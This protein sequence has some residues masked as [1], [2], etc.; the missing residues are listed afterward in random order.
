MRCPRLRPSV[1]A[2]KAETLGGQTS[3]TGGTSPPFPLAPQTPP[4]EKR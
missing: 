3:R 1:E 4:Q 2:M